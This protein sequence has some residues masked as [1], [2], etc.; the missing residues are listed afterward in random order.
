MVVVN[1][2]RRSS[3][4]TA[5]A[6]QSYAHQCDLLVMYGIF[7]AQVQ[8]VKFEVTCQAEFG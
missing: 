8:P 2:K 5:C 6:M 1:T 7:H 3:K 4:L